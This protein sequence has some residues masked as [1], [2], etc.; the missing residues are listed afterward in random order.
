MA[1]WAQ[2]AQAL[3]GARN[4]PLGAHVIGGALAEEEPGAWHAAY[5]V[6]AAGAVL[7]RPDG[8]VA[9]RSA[10]GVADPAAVLQAALDRVLAR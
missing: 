5:G 6:S 2:A 1:P 8:Y 3:A 4:P 9:W 7:V 10:G